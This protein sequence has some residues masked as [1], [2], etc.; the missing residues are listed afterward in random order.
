MEQ[1]TKK[2]NK[3]TVIL[4]IIAAVILAGVIWHFLSPILFPDKHILD[5]DG[6][7]NHRAHELLGVSY[8]EG[9]GS[10][11]G[12]F[13]M[14]IMTD[15]SG[16]LIYTYYHCPYNGAEETEYSCEITKDELYP[17]MQYCKSSLCLLREEG[18]PSEL[19]LLDAPVTTVKFTLEGGTWVTFRS[20]YDYSPEY[21]GIF[22]T[23]HDFLL[24]FFPIEETDNA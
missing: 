18:K 21:N 10:E 3:M 2:V 6:M 11:G 9:G 8:M 15:E 16:K 23:V 20:N 4:L 13:R 5:K 7:I 17:I 14:D 19:I 12:S 1:R 22:T 24:S